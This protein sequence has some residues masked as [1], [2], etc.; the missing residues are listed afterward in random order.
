MTLANNHSSLRF[1][2]FLWIADAASGN[3][4]GEMTIVVS[5]INSSYIFNNTYVKY[6]DQT[7][8]YYIYTTPD[9]PHNGTTAIITIFLKAPSTGSFNVGIK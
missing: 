7:L 6:L 9:I 2:M 8:D 3:N 4:P 1:R 5:G